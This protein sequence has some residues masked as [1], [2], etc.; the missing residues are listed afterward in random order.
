MHPL[1]PATVA[2]NTIAREKKQPT[3]KKA[4]YN[5]YEG[6]LCGRQ[7]SETVDAF[8]AR[9]PPL[10]TPTATY[11]PWLRIGNPYTSFRRTNE[12]Q[13]GFM[14]RGR[15]IL[16][17][18]NTVKTG[19]EASMAG[20]SKAA[21][22]RK[23]TP[24][25]KQLETDLLTTAKEKGCSTGKWMLFPHPDEV[26]SIWSLIATATVNDELGLAAKVAAA[27]ENEPDKARLICVYTEDFE[28]KVDVRRVLERL[29]EMGACNR[30]GAIAEGKVI[31]Y[32][33]DAYTYLDIVGGNE[34]GLRDSLYSSREI[35]GEGR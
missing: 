24:L 7:L 22:T 16:Q 21:I 25:R 11:G 17:D 3:P 31:Y 23:L 32:K 33:T 35:L 34:W 28:D 14:A 26:N 6:D 19:I 29:Y 15:E 5:A 9:C 30:N 27:D 20:K 12:D 18:F 2:Y 10:T 13:A 1:Q 8:L 4:L